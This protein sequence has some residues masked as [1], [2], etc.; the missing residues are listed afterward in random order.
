MKLNTLCIIPHFKNS[1]KMTTILSRLLLFILVCFL[2]H[3][4]H[5]QQDTAAYPW[6]QGKLAALSLSFDDA[7]ESQVLV[8][9]NLLD[10]Y[11]IKA[12]FFVVPSGVEKQ[13]AG[14][15]RA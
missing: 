6:P 12:T 7:R 3:S 1:K 4:L 2:N 13:L 8:G 10:Q 9:T 11:G 15:K 14:W 5:A